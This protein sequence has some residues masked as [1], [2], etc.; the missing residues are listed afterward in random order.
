M[1]HSYRA[2]YYH[3]IWSTKNREPLITNE[4]KS[5]IY[6]YIHGIIKN[7]DGILLSIGGTANHV[8]LLV[9]FRFPDRYFSLVKEI[10]Q[11][12]TL[13]MNKN[14]R[15]CHFLWQEGYGSFSVSYS[16]LERVIHYIKNQE[17]HHKIVTFEEEYQQILKNHQI[18]FDE[19]F[20]FG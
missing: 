18:Q 3:L 15:N 16:T 12:S 6:S 10:K 2:H 1:T 20:V 8:H 9:A 19:R 11:S 13:W 4:L 5:G 14:C 7:H 17:E